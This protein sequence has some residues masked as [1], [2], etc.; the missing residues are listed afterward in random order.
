M[1][2]QPTWD[3]EEIKRNAERQNEIAAELVASGESWLNAVVKAGDILSAE[4][5]TELLKKGVPAR[6]AVNFV[7]SYSRFDWAVQNLARRTLYSML[8]RLWTGA[9]PDD[10]NPQYLELW[11]EAF[12]RNKFKTILDNKRN[13]LPAGML[14]LYR[15]QLGDVPGISWTLDLDI[16]VKFARSGGGRGLVEGGRVLTRTLHSS[17]ALAYLTGRDESEVI[18]DVN[19]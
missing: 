12:R 1:S 14:K 2:T 6:D 5:A 11:K 4:K 16:A 8:P 19:N 18:V 17:K 13:P 10:T 9:D 3:I 7:G 15:G